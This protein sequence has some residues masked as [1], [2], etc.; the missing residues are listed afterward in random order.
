MQ[1]NQKRPSGNGW[2][3]LFS[4]LLLGCNNVSLKFVIYNINDIELE[5]SIRYRL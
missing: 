1:D 5:E 2:P 4:E 3:F